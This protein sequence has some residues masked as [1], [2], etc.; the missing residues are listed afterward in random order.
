MNN[1]STAE[2]NS[3]RNTG[4]YIRSIIMVG[5]MFGFGYI[6]PIEPLT[7]L[8]MQV[9][10]IF[11]ALLF[12]W[13]CVDFVWPS[14]LGMI[15]LGLTEYGTINAVLKEGF[16]NDMVLL[17][18]FV[19]VLSTYLDKIGLTKFI[20]DWFISRKIAVGRPWVFT[21]MIFL[22]AYVLGALISL[23][24]TI[25]IVWTVFYKIVDTIGFKK[26]DQYTSIVLIGI[27]YT[28]MLGYAIFPF[29]ILQAFILGAIE[30]TV[31]LTIDFATF[32]I[33]SFLLTFV[34]LII[35]TLF[36]KYVLR[37]DVTLLKSGT[38]HFADLRG[39]K[40][41][42]SQKIGTCALVLFIF[43]MLAPSFL[44]AWPVMVIIKKFGMTGSLI[45][46][47]VLLCFIRKGN[48]ARVLDFPKMAN[49]NVA[50]EIIILLA[51][52]MPL[53]HAI[54]SPEL[55]IMELVGVILTPI[56]AN[57]TPWMFTLLVVL[58]GGVVTQVVHNLVLAAILVPIMCNFAAVIGLNPLLVAIPL[59]L[60]LN[61]ANTTPAASTAGTLPFANTEWLKTKDVYLQSFYCFLINMAVTLTIG[62]WLANIFVH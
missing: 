39:Q 59:S 55:H 25:V 31:G 3:K 11:I 9:I 56:F 40:M 17:I 61:I 34:C 52:T 23:A 21:L 5:I 49:C 58:I 51:A 37:P 43:L 48:G 38:D 16:G 7:H 29:K 45:V 44:P 54:S 35:Y 36:C 32:T 8:S 53:S 20:A 50:W 57:L 41:N 30:K 13:T 22:T 28:A 6:P 12:A 42:A 60:V 46:V 26:T 24:A 2:N 10:G 19:F 14:L 1:T 18:F 62:V 4:Y 47:L 33:A 15:A 27:V